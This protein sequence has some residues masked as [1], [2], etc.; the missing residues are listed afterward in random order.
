MRLV[1]I[2]AVLYAGLCVLAR[3]TFRKMLYPAPPPR[4]FV[5]AGVPTIDL[6]ELRASDGVAVHAAFVAP[7]PGA[8]T[9]VFFHGNGEQIADSVPLARDLAQRGFGVALVEYRGYGPSSGPTPTETG[10]YLDAEAVLDALAARGIAPAGVTL[11]GTSLGSGVAAEM[12]RRGR[13]AAL[14][15][16][17]PYTSVPAVASRIAPFLPT[18]LCVADHFDTLAKAADIR[19][20]TLVI[21]GDRDEVIPYDMGELLA[22]TIV[23]ARFISVPGGHHNDLFDRD[24]VRL[25]NEID[26]HARR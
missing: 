25:M 5:A 26:A 1:V 22:R 18:R 4:P 12:A 23:G 11:W 6:L 15:L 2:G 16:V 19:V 14:V 3:L 13:G 10:I 17:T 21:H 20:P 8:R 7:P 9:V 24:G